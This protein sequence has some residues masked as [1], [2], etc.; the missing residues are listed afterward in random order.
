MTTSEGAAPF[1]PLEH[2]YETLRGAIPACRGCELYEHATQAVMGE[3]PT[4]GAI[5]FV[6]EAPGDH[7]DIEGK[8]FV[9]PA[10]EV[11]DKA[12]DAIG[13]LR[14][15]I[16]VSNAVKHFKFTLRGK[17]RIHETPRASE[18]RACRPWVEA[19][20]DAVKPTLIVLMGGTAVQSLLD[21]S[22]KVLANRGH[23]IESDYGPCLI[24]VHPSSILRVPD[25]EWQEPAFKAFVADIR[26][27]LPYLDAAGR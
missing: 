2:R 3:G 9:G 26:K 8:P 25:P 16:Y 4:S 1:V 20:I 10:G 24:T 12:L 7:E 13:L 14:K 21:S 27:V 15:D 5:M 22:T 11:F 23:I 6:G 18:I 17:R 19:E